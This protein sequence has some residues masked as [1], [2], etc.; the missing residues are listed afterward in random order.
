MNNTSAYTIN[1]HTHIIQQTIEKDSIIK[2]ISQS[3]EVYQE[4]LPTQLLF[5]FETSYHIL[6]F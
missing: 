3:G 2:K 5:E 1:S 4:C 6:I